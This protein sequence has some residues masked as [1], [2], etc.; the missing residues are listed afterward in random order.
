[1]FFIEKQFSREKRFSTQVKKHNL[2]S[3]YEN[4]LNDDDKNKNLYLFSEFKFDSQSFLKSF[5]ITHQSIEL[6]LYTLHHLLIFV[7]T[8]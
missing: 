7:I 6:V 8:I 1:M 5:F 2:N 3:I 4:I